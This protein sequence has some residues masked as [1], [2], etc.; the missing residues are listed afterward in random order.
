M[1]P[2]LNVDSSDGF[3]EDIVMRLI[4]GMD[5]SIRCRNYAYC[6]TRDKGA[7]RKNMLKGYTKIYQKAKTLD[8]AIR[9]HAYVQ[10]QL[11]LS[12]SCKRK[13]GAGGSSDYSDP[14]SN[15]N[16]R[17]SNKRTK[18]DP[19]DRTKDMRFMVASALKS[20]TV[21]IKD[22]EKNINL[23]KFALAKYVKRR[24]EDANRSKVSL[25]QP[26]GALMDSK[27]LL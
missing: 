11:Q 14:N 4:E 22:I 16:N 26:A 23:M 13:K 12:S 1:K 15:N 2:R 3:F 7:G 17:T 27:A 6:D 5:E 19:K 21:R 8:K 10:E 25:Q 24:R 18:L 9:R 20:R